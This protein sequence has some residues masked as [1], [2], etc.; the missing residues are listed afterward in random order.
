MKTNWGPEGLNQAEKYLM[1]ALKID[2]KHANTKVLLGYVYT[3]QKRYQEAELK[4]QPLAHQ[5]SGYG[6]IGANF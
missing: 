4:H 5:I 3:H 1:S 2:A 6:L